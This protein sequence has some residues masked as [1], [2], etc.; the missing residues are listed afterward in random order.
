MAGKRERSEDGLADSEALTA[1]GL[2]P[3]LWV[4]TLETWANP[5]VKALEEKFFWNYLFFK[6]AGSSC[7]GVRVT[8]AEDWEGG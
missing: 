8:G 7:L 2:S 4:S 3:V 5:R 1:N 6:F